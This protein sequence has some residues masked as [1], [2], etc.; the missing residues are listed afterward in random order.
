MGSSSH[1][2]WNPD[3]LPGI[4]LCYALDP[5]PRSLA[6]LLYSR[7]DKMATY[8]EKDLIRILGKEYIAYENECQNGVQNYCKEANQL[9]SRELVNCVQKSFHF[10]PY[11]ITNC[12]LT[13]SSQ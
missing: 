3:V 1:V 9:P 6:C 8:E 10:F 4:F 11:V 5:F 13:S 7:H 12:Q 2:S